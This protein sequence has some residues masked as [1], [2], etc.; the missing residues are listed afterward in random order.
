MKDPDYRTGLFGSRE[1]EIRPRR[2][3]G[4]PRSRVPALRRRCPRCPLPVRFGLLKG[5]GFPPRWR[6]AGH[7]RLGL[8]FG[9]LLG[10]RAAR[11][12][13]D[14]VLYRGDFA[15]HAR[16]DADGEALVDGLA[17]LLLVLHL[18]A[19]GDERRGWREQ[20]SSQGYVDARNLANQGDDAFFGALCLYLGVLLALPA[21]RYHEERVRHPPHVGVARAQLCDGHVVQVGAAVQDREVA[22][23]LD[24]EA[25][26]P[27]Y[28]THRGAYRDFVDLRVHLL[29]VHGEELGGEGFAEEERVVD[30]Q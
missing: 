28:L 24:V 19:L 29:A 7:G 21:L 20:T 16:P 14:V 12:G 2:A 30:V 22:G 13:D 11:D 10:Y 6:A 15:P 18:V 5:F 3:G 8:G 25:R 26:D 23:V 4:G 17:Y 1:E 27:E 9:R